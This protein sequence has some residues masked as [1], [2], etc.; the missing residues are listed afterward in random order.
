M[1]AAE[2]NAARMGPARE[3]SEDE[4]TGQ[5]E[6]TPTLYEH[7]VAEQ[8]ALA[9]MLAAEADRLERLQKEIEAWEPAAGWLNRNQEDPGPDQTAESRARPAAPAPRPGTSPFAFL[10]T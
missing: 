6:T 5:T 2:K 8:A 7:L 10:H 3:Q 4:A 9:E 1:A